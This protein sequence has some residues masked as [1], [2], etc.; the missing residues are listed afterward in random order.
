[1]NKSELHRVK[2]VNLG[3]AAIA[4]C[5][6]QKW[7]EGHDRQ[8]KSA[9][10]NHKK[11]A[12]SK[13]DQKNRKSLRD[14]QVPDVAMLQVKERKV[15]DGHVNKN[16]NGLRQDIALPHQLERI[17]GADQSNNIRG[18]RR[19]AKERPANMCEQESC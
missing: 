15:Q 4:P 5:C 18:S 16:A 1:M 11:V 14:S 8:K 13:T 6:Q 12:H 9:Y 19:Q 17:K 2:S 7:I 3:T 10:L